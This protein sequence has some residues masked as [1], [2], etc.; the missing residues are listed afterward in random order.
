MARSSRRKFLSR[1][2]LGLMG[3]VVANRS[4]AAPASSEPPGA[5]PAFGTAPG[6]GPEV[7]PVTFTEAA[8]LAQVPLTPAEAQQAASN[9]RGMMA[10]LLERRTGPRRVVL[11]PELA[12]ASRWEPLGTKA[13][14]AKG[15]FVRGKA[16]AGPLP[17]REEDIAF[18]PVSQ[19]SRW[20]ESRA[21]TS[22]RLTRLY[23]ARLERFDPQLKCVITLTPELALA[24]ARRAGRHVL[25]VVASAGSTAT[26][27]VDPL[28]AVA[29]FCARHGLWFHVD[30]AHGASAVLSPRYRGLLRGIERAD[31]VVWDAHKMMLMPALITAV[32]FRDGARSFDAFAQEASY[33]FHG[34]QERAWHDVAQRTLE[35]TKEMMALKLYTCLSVLGT[36][37]FQDA[38]EGSFDLARAFAH[39]LQA[40]EDFELAVEPECNIVCFRHTPR[41]VPEG[42]LDAL[43]AR[44]R[45]T[46]VTLV[47]RLQAAPRQPVDVLHGK[48]FDPDVQWKLSLRLLEDMGFDLE[49]GRQDKSIHPFSSGLHPTD[50]RLTTD[51]DPDSLGGL[52]S[53]LHEGGHGLYE[54]GFH[55]EHARTPLANAPSMGLHE[56]QSRLWENL[57]GRGRPFWT[58]Y[59]PL[60]REAF[61]EALGGLDLEAFLGGINRVTPSLIRVDADE[62]TYNL[63]IVLRYELE[64]LLIRDELP[65]DDLPAAWNERMQ[66]FLGVQPPDDVQGVLQDIH[67][68]WGEFGYFPTYALG[69]LYAA[70]LYATARR[71]LPGLEAGL[72]RGELRPLRDWLRTHIHAEGYRLPAEERVRQVT[73]EGLTEDD[74]LAYL[75]AKYG[76]LY[77]VKL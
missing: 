53:S 8:K 58:H 46:L 32:L 72:A 69:N 68:A 17:T 12:P 57:V 26:G 1:S 28:E 64:L 30:G 50:V 24:Q 67:W 3:A 27:A 31:S 76:A 77:G 42:E 45:E 20:V 33:L 47:G 4:E 61:P 43:Q 70:S 18:A 65:L 19:L 14:T 6:V 15:R 22:E 35:C 60:L 7:G 41:G 25:A 37:V 54:Q 55:P 2:A 9:W 66:R 51:L 39:K 44:L 73:G 52:F 48:R 23:L 59:F 74:F 62:V 21:L 34:Q 38:L 11:E 40:A 36:R 75:R 10:P 29:D 5:P 56:S 71:A 63:H 16:A 49:A 13:P